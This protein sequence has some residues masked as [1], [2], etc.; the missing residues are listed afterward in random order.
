MKRNVR[1]MKLGTKITLTSMVIALAVSLLIS[2][3]SIFYMRNYLLN[4]S[5]SHTMSV[6]ETAAT[7]VDGALI[8]GIQAGD[9]GTEAYAEVL[10]QLQAFLVDEDIEYIYTMR[11][12]E[13]TVQ[14]V[15]DADTE[16]GAAIG[17]EYETY[18]KIDE[19][20]AG[21]ISMD[22]EVT[23]DEWGS[24][25][26]AFAPITNEEG[27]VVAIVGVDCSINSINDKIQ[28]MVK[29][30]VIVEVIC[31]A[32]AFVVSMFTGRL[33]A[34]NVLT[35]NRKMDE[36]AG[37]DGDLTQKIQLHSGDEIENVANSFNRFMVKLRSMMLSVKDSGERL[38]RATNQTNEELQQA[39]DELNRIS[40]SLNE[41]TLTMQETGDSV[42]EIQE[43]ASAVKSMSADLYQ[44]TRSGAE[45][46]D[47]VSR[48][49]EQESLNCQASKAQMSRLMGEMSANLSRKVEESA[50]IAQIIEL[51]NSI[52]AI[53]QQTRM[54]SLN[55]SIEAARAGE[56]GKG[57]AV[58]AEEVGNLAE[59]TAQT[60]KEIEDINKFTVDTVNGLVDISKEMLTFVEN[61]ISKDYDKMVGVGE[62]Y[63]KDSVEFMEK[64]NQFCRL[65][66]QLSESM[67]T[68][69]GHIRRIT[70]VIETE[71]TGI[72]DVAAFSDKIYGKMQT[73][74]ANGKINEEIV[75]ELGDMLDKFKV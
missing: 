34:R 31:I 3:I 61:V 54:L 37:T 41:M 48:T 18:D 29:V 67:D 72:T 33:M 32:L 7:V 63:H 49:A 40:N 62:A 59:A 51:T 38:E 9:E 15:V 26:S 30:L 1:R 22:D 14:F 69:E 68:I 56:N 23:T 53:S 58:V 4:V 57:F 45:Y 20:F 6:A 25:Y 17:E 64:F 2:G 24:Y 16:E 43:A 70:E 11:Q 27:K 35:I 46:A 39:T 13:G 42:T 71:T 50:K 66:E 65:S 60:A 52:I 75:G 5:R 19:A 36:L 21:E 12:A 28:D 55:A 44:Q 47:N 10:A 73:A 8:D 74:N